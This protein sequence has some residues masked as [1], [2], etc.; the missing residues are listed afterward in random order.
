MPDVGFYNAV[1]KIWLGEKPV[2]VSLKPA[3]LGAKT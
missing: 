3:L 2:D 1:L